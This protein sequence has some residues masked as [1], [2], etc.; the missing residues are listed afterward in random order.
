MLVLDCVV[1]RGFGG[2]W[3]SRLLV[4]IDGARQSLG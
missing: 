1:V 4:L 3:L 2:C